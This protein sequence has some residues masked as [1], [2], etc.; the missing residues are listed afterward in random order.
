[1]EKSLGDKVK[2]LSLRIKP[3]C[4]HAVNKFTSR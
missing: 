1:M 3:V 2:K 4:K